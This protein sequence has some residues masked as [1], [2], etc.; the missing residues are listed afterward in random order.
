MRHEDEQE[1][2]NQHDQYQHQP[3]AIHVDSEPTMA[4]SET[5]IEPAPVP[6]IVVPQMMLNGDDAAGDTSED[7]DDEN[8]VPRMVVVT[9]PEEADESVPTEVGGGGGPSV[10]RKPFIHADGTKKRTAGPR[11]ITPLCHHRVT[12]ASSSHSRPVPQMIVTSTDDDDA[13]THSEPP[14]GHHHHDHDHNRPQ[15]ATDHAP[16]TCAGCKQ[17]IA[18]RIVNALDARWHPD[19]FTCQHCS[20]VLEHVAFY[21]HEGRAYCGVDYDEVY[22]LIPLLS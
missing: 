11:T 13:P 9:T 15:R 2:W 17:L 12:S 5:H 7:D 6:T 10:S 21:E 8:T 14:M 19:C 22:H 18:G 4:A 3:P 20:L 1:N 16:L